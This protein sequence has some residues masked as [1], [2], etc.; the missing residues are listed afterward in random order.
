MSRSRGRRR[1]A[2]AGR[3]PVP[4]HFAGGQAIDLGDLSGDAV[5]PVFATFAYFGETYRVNPD[6]TE[7]LV[8]DLLAE[9]AHVDVDDPRSAGRSEPTVAQNAERSKDYVRQ[10]IHPDDF[11]AMWSAAKANRQSIE[12]LLMLCWTLLGKISAR[13]GE[14]MVPTTPPSDS[15][16]GR[17]ITSQSLPDGA[18]SQEDDEAAI[19]GSWWPE[20]LPRNETA[21]RVVERFEARGRP[22]LA[23]QIMV[24]QEAMAASAA[25]TG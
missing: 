19:D 6:L 5:E 17:Q 11:E 10:H 1:S 13:R 14:G 22:D 12:Q 16:A 23:C 20:N 8:V 15:S 7:T 2:L 9:A 24:T 18:S 25:R 4:T 21:I 3:P